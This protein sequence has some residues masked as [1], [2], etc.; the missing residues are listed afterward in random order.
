MGEQMSDIYVKGWLPGGKKQKTDVHYR[1]TLY[2]I[3]SEGLLKFKLIIS[4]GRI[5]I[6]GC[7]I[8][9]SCHNWIFFAN[10]YI[11]ENFLLHIDYN[12][13]VCLHNC[14]FIADRWMVMETLTGDLCSPLSICLQ[15]RCL[16]TSRR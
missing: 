11:L 8:P 5:E 7:N 3:V 4:A 14:I 6:T 1:Y 9:R 12:A 10:L 15:S 2:I 16:S 13:C